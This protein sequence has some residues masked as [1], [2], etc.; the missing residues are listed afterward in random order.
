MTG[1][2]LPACKKLRRTAGCQ[3]AKAVSIHERIEKAKLIDPDTGWNSRGYLPHYD[4]KEVIQFVTYRLADSLPQKLLERN[5]LLFKV[6]QITEIEYHR[7]IELLLDQSVGPD[8]LKVPD[9]ARMVE[10]NLLHF[11]G[12]RYRLLHWVLMSNHVHVLLVPMN[13]YSLSSIMHSLKSYT[14]NQA[15]RI[16]ARTGSFWSVEYFD[17]YIR[18]SE[19]FLS[20]V[21]YIHNNPVKAGLCVN[22][23]D[24]RFGCARRHQ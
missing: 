20:T 9:I 24:W 6:G 5:T 8:H 15:N 23:E 7:R 4:E 22:P 18:N 21:R 11:D 14:S 10:D 13:G 12:K 1:R 3:P 17:R 19:H 2:R 16:L